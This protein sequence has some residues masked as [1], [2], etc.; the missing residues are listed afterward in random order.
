M[1]IAPAIATAKPDL[2]NEEDEAASD[3]SDN[4]VDPGNN[5]GSSQSLVVDMADVNELVGKMGIIESVEV[6]ESVA[7]AVL[8]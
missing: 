7:T 3:V 5:P 8:F 1:I 2:P 4:G 6:V